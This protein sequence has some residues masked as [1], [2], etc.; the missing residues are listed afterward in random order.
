VPILDNH[1]LRGAIAA[2]AVILATSC[3]G[4]DEPAAPDT[5]VASVSLSAS[6]TTIEPGTT[7]QLTATA[8]N[9]AGTALPGTATWASNTQSVATV[10]STGLVTGVANGTATISATIAGK[11]ATRIFTV[12]TITA[13][14][15]ASVAATPSQVFTPQQ[16]D[17][18]AGGTVTWNFGTLGHNVTFQA[19]AAGTPANIPETANGNV[20]RT[21]TT[22]G[23]YP[24][25]CT[26]H[27][28]MSGTVVVH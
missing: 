4:S 8:K 20:S 2:L 15:T 28:G 16:V 27:I 7:V 26:I 11:V 25:Q 12:Q 1:R 17:I 21:F 19:G 24:Y 18:T 13:G 5:T 6:A 23:T 3:G 9:A 22:A 14:P 10:S